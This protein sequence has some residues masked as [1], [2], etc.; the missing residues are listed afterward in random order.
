V[1]GYAVAHCRVATTGELTECQITKE[2]PEK[3]GFKAA[4]LNL[5]RKFRILPA[6]ALTP[7]PTPLWVDLPIR[8]PPPGDV[9]QPT[10][11]APIWLVQFDPN[12]APKVFPPEAAAQGLTTGV[13][14]ARCTVAS[15]GSLTGCSPAPGDPD[16]LGFSEAA[17]T[18][19]SVMKMNLWSADAAP[20]AG[21]VAL[22]SIR[23]NL[24]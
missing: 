19:A 17:V 14:V 22:I 11:K 9:E 6:L 21:A 15:D 3:L 12:N 8:F 16:G 5:S 2:I 13:G 24:K 23:L 4:A 10:V 18:L 7:T 20:V 1:E